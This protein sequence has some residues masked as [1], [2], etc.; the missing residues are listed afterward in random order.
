MFQVTFV[1]SGQV[2]YI[3]A[4][5]HIFGKEIEQ[6]AAPVGHPLMVVVEVVTTDAGSQVGNQF[7]V[8]HEA[9]QGVETISEKIDIAVG[10]VV[11]LQVGAAQNGL[12]AEFLAQVVAE[13]EAVG[14]AVVVNGLVAFHE[15]PAKHGGHGYHAGFQLGQGG[16]GYQQA[17]HDQ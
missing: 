12:K 4:Q 1:K 15:Y 2:P 8:G 11:A 9:I 13:S 6:A 7:V 10:R 14:K 16:C 5:G 17:S 3:G